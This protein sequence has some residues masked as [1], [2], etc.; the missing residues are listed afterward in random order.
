MN[1][2]SKERLDEIARDVSEWF[3][4]RRTP[5]DELIAEI[6]ACWAERDDAANDYAKLRDECAHWKDAST[7]WQREAERLKDKPETTS[8]DEEAIRLLDKIGSFLFG[9]EDADCVDYAIDLEVIVTR[10]RAAQKATPQETTTL[11]SRVLNWMDYAVAALRG[12]EGFDAHEIANN[13]VA[14]YQDIDRSRRAAKRQPTLKWQTNKPTEPCWCVCVDFVGNKQCLIRATLY[15]EDEFAK[16]A[17]KGNSWD[18]YL[19]IP[20]PMDPEKVEKPRRVECYTDEN[21]DVRYAGEVRK[22]DTVAMT[23]EQYE[24]ALRQKSAERELTPTQERLLSGHYWLWGGTENSW[25][26]ITLAEL[27]DCI[28]VEMKR[29]SG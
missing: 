10:L 14:L 20:A 24:K 2:M 29:R 19:P 23:P 15:Q 17:K 28:E 4:S 11:D 21:G 26:Q 6:R 9:K 5:A 13:G 7:Y 25:E 12:R 3:Y 22:G 27:V 8:L 16:L 18:L 1:R